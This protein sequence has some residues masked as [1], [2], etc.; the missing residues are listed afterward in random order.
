MSVVCR[1]QSPGKP[2]DV[3]VTLNSLEAVSRCCVTAEDGRELIMS[4]TFILKRNRILYNIN[5]RPM[6]ARRG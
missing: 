1:E 4:S 2:A 5:E 3:R 6:W